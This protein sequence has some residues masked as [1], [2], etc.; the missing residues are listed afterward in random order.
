MLRYYPTPLDLRAPGLLEVVPGPDDSSNKSNSNNNGN[1]NGNSNSNGDSNCNH[2][3]DNTD[4][5]DNNNTNQHN[6]MVDFGES[7]WHHLLLK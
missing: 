3:S 1:S 7:L 2:S 6:N 4:T 5:N